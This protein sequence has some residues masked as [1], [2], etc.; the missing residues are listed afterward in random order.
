MLKRIK[1]RDKI[2]SLWNFI[3]FLF[4]YAFTDT[5]FNF[6]FYLH[7]KRHLALC[8]SNIIKYIYSKILIV[9]S[10]S[11]SV[12][13]RLPEP[14]HTRHLHVPNLPDIIF[15]LI[16]FYV[17]TLPDELLVGSGPGLAHPGLSQLDGL[18]TVSH[19]HH[20]THAGQG[21]PP[22]VSAAMRGEYVERNVHKIGI[23]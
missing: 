19:S 22:F 16:Y 18:V 2:K 5:R 20:L 1:H 23:W 11:F 7:K 4:I 14:G 15:F 6:K 9:M 12:E 8:A 3:Y 10:S 13:E 21:E 17:S